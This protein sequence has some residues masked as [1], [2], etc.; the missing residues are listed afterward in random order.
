M[1]ENYFQ[2]KIAL[3]EKT[4]SRVKTQLLYLPQIPLVLKGL[5]IHFKTF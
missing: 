5:C 2:R 1:H 4:I 3:T